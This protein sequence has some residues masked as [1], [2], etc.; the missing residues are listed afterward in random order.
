MHTDTQSARTLARQAYQC[1]RRDIVRGVL[2]AGS[3]LKLNML[4]KR[5][6]VGMSPLREALARLVGD[7]L[8][9]REDQRGFWVETLS[10]DE[11]ADITYARDLIETEALQLSIMRGDEAW[12]SRVNAAFEA[13][14]SVEDRLPSPQQEIPRTLVDEWERVHDDFHYALISACGSPWLIRLQEM[15]YSQAE[16]YR[17]VSLQSSRGERFVHDEHIA[18]F[19]AARERNAT[20]VCRLLHNHLNR[21]YEEVRKV[22]EKPLGA[23]GGRRND[24]AGNS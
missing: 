8:V 20:R 3:K 1:L 12:E 17:C 11:L 24:Q 16:R 5:Y 21:T 2:P 18:I 9:R 23:S 4:M 22:M 7:Q 10:L 15:M 14:S 13:L 6:S 19:E